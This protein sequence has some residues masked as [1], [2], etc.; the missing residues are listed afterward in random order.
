M[1]T[2]NGSVWLLELCGWRAIA[3]RARH[4]CLTCESACRIAMSRRRPVSVV[5]RID[6][7]RSIDNQTGAPECSAIERLCLKPTSSKYRIEPQA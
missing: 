3:R 7:S 2:D 1:R 4:L 6:E 5:D